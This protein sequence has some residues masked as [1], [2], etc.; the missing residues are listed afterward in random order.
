MFLWIIWMTV[1]EVSRYIPILMVQV[2]SA[3]ADLAKNDATIT[4]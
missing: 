2:F 4:Q 3:S 1:R